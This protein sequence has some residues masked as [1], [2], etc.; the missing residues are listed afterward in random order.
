MTRI[1]RA[2]GKSDFKLANPLW[3]KDAIIYELH[4]RAFLDSNGDGI[5]DFGGLIE[6]LDYL[7]DLGIT[8]L[9]ILPFFPS[10]LK[11]DGYDI[12]GYTD[13]NPI[14]GNLK[15]FKEFLNEAHKRG[16]FVIC[17]LVLNHTSDQHPWFQKARKSEGAF[18]DFYVWSQTPDKYKDARIIFQDLVFPLYSTRSQTGPS[19]CSGLQRIFPSLFGKSVAGRT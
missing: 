10:P 7:A 2:R 8:A 19:Y 11:D 5:G 1:V 17:E 18:R 13:I 4:I 9:W 12:A 16:I 14:Y 15:M 3:Y 6:K